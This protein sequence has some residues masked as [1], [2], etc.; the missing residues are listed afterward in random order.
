MLETKSFIDDSGFTLKTV[1]IC[2]WKML[3]K[4]QKDHTSVVICFHF[5][6]GLPCF[7]RVYCVF[8]W[9]RWCGAR[10]EGVGWGGR[11]YETNKSLKLSRFAWRALRPVI[12]SMSALRHEN[13]LR[14][15]LQQTSSA[16]VWR[17]AQWRSSG[18]VSSSG[19]HR[20]PIV[21]PAD[22][23]AATP[24]HL[25]FPAGG[26]RAGQGWGGRS[27]GLAIFQCQ[28]GQPGWV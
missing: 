10:E 8:G 27:P 13:K 19:P 20:A 15:L 11:G 1:G 28:R 16:C 4:T 25:P 18:P 12:C 21:W 5:L 17:S 14:S 3:N 22:V 7:S 6:C 23:S 9:R 26:G 2:K 24:R